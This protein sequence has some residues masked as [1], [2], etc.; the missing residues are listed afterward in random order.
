[1]T[2]AQTP[3]PDDF[4]QSTGL[5]WLWSLLFGWIWFM[6]HGFYG[7]AVL[8]LILQLTIIGYLIIPFIAYGAWRERAEAD[9]KAE[10]TMRALEGRG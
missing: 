4:N 9:A 5:T 8:V 7:K 10:R 3:N 2:P 6:W 1:M